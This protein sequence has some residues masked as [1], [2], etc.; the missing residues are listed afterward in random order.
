MFT[1]R[2]G[3]RADKKNIAVVLTDGGS[4]R[5]SDTIRRALELKQKAHVLVV[6]V[7][8]WLDEYELNGNC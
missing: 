7:G 1:S 2:F 5:K 8:N 3:D 4:N 6:A